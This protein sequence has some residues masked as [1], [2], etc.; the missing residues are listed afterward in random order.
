MIKFVLAL[1]FLSSNALAIEVSPG[2]DRNCF[3]IPGATITVASATQA[4]AGI[5][6]LAHIILPANTLDRDGDRIY[7]TAIATFTATNQ[8]KDFDIMLDSNTLTG[9]NAT[10][11]RTSGFNE[12]TIVRRYGSVLAYWGRNDIGGANVEASIGTLSINTASAM[13]LTTKAS[14]AAGLFADVTQLYFTAVKCPAP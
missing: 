14:S 5:A 9:A 7:V 13:T 6:S 12:A 11:T 4:S 10:S 2:P 8:V 1:L 3:P